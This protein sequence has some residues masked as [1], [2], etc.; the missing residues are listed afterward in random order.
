MMG[1][2]VQ[3]IKLTFVGK[4]GASKVGSLLG[5]GGYNLQ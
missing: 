4:R 2:H 5:E 3:R 1:P